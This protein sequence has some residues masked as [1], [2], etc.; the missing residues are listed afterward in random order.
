MLNLRISPIEPQISTEVPRQKSAI[1]LLD[2]KVS[3]HWVYIWGGC[4]NVGSWIGR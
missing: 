4:Q 1:L 3:R 2:S